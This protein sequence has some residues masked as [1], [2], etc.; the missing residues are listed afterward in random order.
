MTE[1]FGPKVP[2]FDHIEFR[3]FKP[4]FPNIRKKI[5]KTA[6]IMVESVMGEGD[7]PIP[8]W[9]LKYLEKICREKNIVNFR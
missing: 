7:K 3:N 4:R 8:D 5:K 9:C 1:G 2:G 6:A